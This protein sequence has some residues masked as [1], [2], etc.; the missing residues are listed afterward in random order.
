MHL[1]IG[2][3]SLDLAKR[4][5]NSHPN[6]SAIAIDIFDENY[7]LEIDDIKRVE[8][9]TRL[10]KDL[11]N[12]SVDERQ[13]IHQACLPIVEHNYHHFYS[14]AF[15]NILWTELNT[16]LNEFTTQKGQQ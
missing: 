10:L 11:N 12:L 2:D 5:T 3:I 9:V 16:M 13:K 6:A 1:T 8:K 14:G 15:A 4:K 7:D